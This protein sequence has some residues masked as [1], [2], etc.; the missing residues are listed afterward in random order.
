VERGNTSG[1][2][3]NRALARR[4]FPGVDPVGRKLD[5]ETEIVGVV[6]DMRQA[7]VAEEPVPTLFYRF[8]RQAFRYVTLHVRTAG[9]P[10][11][12]AP[13][14][15]REIRAATPGAP[16]PTVQPMNER[17]A[18]SLA[19]ARM[20][21][22]FASLLGGLA[23]CLAAVG[24]Y[25]VVAYSVAGRTHEIGVRMALGA[26]RGDVVAMV[27]RGGARLA[28]IGVV[29]GTVAAV[30]ATRVIRGVL[31]DVEPTDPA[32]FAAGAALLVAVTLLASWLPARRAARVTPT[33]AL[34]AE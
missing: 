26:D 3:V 8:P 12:L 6:G 7:A 18:E 22:T 19:R 32:T 23:L 27:V 21:V 34:R 24:L 29:V 2:L 13:A 28:L 10:A 1:V 4:Y 25:G 11:A 9:D 33:S 17:V 20:L 30:A 31:Y 15:A 5:D 14:V 16:P